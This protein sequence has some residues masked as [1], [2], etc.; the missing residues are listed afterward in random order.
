MS[1]LDKPEYDFLKT[2]P[3]LGDNIILLGYG[4]SIAYGTNLPTSDTDIRGI[5]TRSAHDI[6]ATKRFDQVV[7]NTTDTT[8]YS[9]EKIFNL[10]SNCNPNTIELLGL[11]PEHYVY[12]NKYG[13]EILA[14]KEIF[15]SK[16]ASYS[17]GGYANAQLRRLDNKSARDL[18]Q[19]EQ[20]QH[21]LNS[22]KN[23]KY[24]FENK[25]SQMD[26]FEMV[27]DK[28]EREDMNSE[29]FLNVSLNHYPA[30]DY[31]GMWSEIKDIIRSYNTIGKR[32]SKAIEREK[33]GKHMMHLVRLYLMAFDILEKKQIITYRE[34]EH[35]F[36]M[37]IRN[38]KY[39]NGTQPT[40][41]FRELINQYEKRLQYAEK[42]TDLPDKPN[43]KEIN[44]L[45][46]T[47]NKEIVKDAF[48]G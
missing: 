47:I 38:G 20:E 36:L 23:A 44:E 7:D 30:R 18:Q 40:E 42:N 48:E 28:S 27:I 45:L 39:L 46:Y 8:I 41:E 12:L 11:K 9:V 25:Y 31:L 1:I 15:L 37:D 5:A 19:E 16:I 21:I 34:K 29:I 4:G 32:N 14:N 2:N 3:L 10:L 13:K 22:I 35:D 33:L 43:Y 17:F 6:L 24:H 26:K